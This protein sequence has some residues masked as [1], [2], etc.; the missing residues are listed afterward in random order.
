MKTT[1]LTTA[2]L[3]ITSCTQAQHTPVVTL[4]TAAN[5]L[6]PIQQVIAY[7]GEVHDLR[8]ELQGKVRSLEVAAGHVVVFHDRED[9]EG[10]QTLRIEGPMRINDLGTMPMLGL[11]SNWS[12]AIASMTIRACTEQ[13]LPETPVDPAIACEPR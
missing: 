9:L 5:G 8:M 1:L 13:Q 11:N 7:E 4:W 12:G 6:G 10:G 3:L 2:L